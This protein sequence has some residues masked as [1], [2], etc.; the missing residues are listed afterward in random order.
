MF[1]FGKGKVEIQLN[2]FNFAPGEVIEGTM[3]I[4]LKKPVKGRKVYVRLMATERTSSRRVTFGGGMRPSRS[5]NYS[6]AYDFT[7]PLDGEKEYPPGTSQPYQFRITV[8][9]NLNDQPHVG[10]ALGGIVKTM[11]TL[12]GY[13]RSLSWKLIGGIDTLGFDVKKKLEIN[14]V[15]P[16]NNPNTIQ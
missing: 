14:V 4:T 15:A 5:T 7:Q 13:S 8:P 9:T 12:S 10:G 2:K 3:I 6:T 16:A 11:Q 1:G